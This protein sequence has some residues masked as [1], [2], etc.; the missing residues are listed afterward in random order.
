MS[1]RDTRRQIDQMRVAERGWKNYGTSIPTGYPNNVPFFRTDLGWWIYYDGA[2]QLTA[3]EYVLDGDTNTTPA[4]ATGAYEW[5]VRQD[6]APYVTRCTATSIVATTNN[7]TNFW[8]LRFRG[9]NLARTT[10]TTIHDFTTA[11]DSVATYS[12]K[13]SV[14]SAPAPA[15]KNTIQLLVLKTLT[16]GALTIVSA[17]VYYRLIIP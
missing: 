2:Q 8:T 17:S 6:Y 5:Q 12:L 11:A 10:V 14:P 3:Y 4:D 7:A 15:N 16:P 9:I 1:D 13:D